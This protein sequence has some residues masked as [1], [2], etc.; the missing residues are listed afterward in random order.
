MGITTIRSRSQ[1][2]LSARGPGATGPERDSSSG[3][4]NLDT[5][6]RPQPSIRLP[7]PLYPARFIRRPNRFVVRARLGSSG[8]ESTESE[9][10]LGSADG[11]SLPAGISAGA[12]VACHL[13]DPGRLTELLVPGARLLLRHAPAP[14]RKTEWSVV[15]VRAPANDGWVSVDTTLPNRLVERALRDRALDELRGWSLERTEFTRGSSRF[16]FLLSGDDGRRMAMEVKSVTLVEGEVGLFPDAVTARGDRHVEELAEIAGE[17]DWE[18]AVLFVCQRDDARRI[19]AAR[20]I[21]PGFAEA[22]ARANEAGVRVLGRRCRVD[23]RRVVLG[24]AVPAR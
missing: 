11:A 9:S 12:E 5:M 21:D 7:S 23:R 13:A 14:H 19:R 2:G 3:V 10:G 8:P 17:P 18:A 20:S 22:L 4:L 6:T 24:D 16:D 1:Q 15:L